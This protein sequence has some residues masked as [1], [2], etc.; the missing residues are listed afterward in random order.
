MTAKS[1]I[2]TTAF[3][4]PR[5][6]IEAE[7]LLGDIGQL[8]R[9]VARIEQ[10]MNDKLSGIKQTFEEKAQPL[11]QE[12]EAKFKALHAWGEA[13]RE[14]LLTGRLKTVKL[15]TGE[16]SWRMTPPKVLIRTQQVVMETLKRL[17]MGDL[18]RTKEEINKEAILAD[19]ERVAGI[20][21]IQITQAEEFVAKPFESEIECFE[22]VKR[23]AA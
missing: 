22:P 12:I 23:E 3:P 7:Q 15:T 2:K 18:I 21:G 11:N 4:V 20:K 9:Q 5:S 10:D 19:P 17:G 14:E 16:I 13:N 8:Q 6:Q 1:R